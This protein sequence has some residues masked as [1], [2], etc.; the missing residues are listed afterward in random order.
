MDSEKVFYMRRHIFFFFATVFV[1]CIFKASR[2]ASETSTTMTEVG[3]QMFVI[4]IKY[5]IKGSKLQ[6]KRIQDACRCSQ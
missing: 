6:A 3:N 2:A 4:K 1:S 5:S